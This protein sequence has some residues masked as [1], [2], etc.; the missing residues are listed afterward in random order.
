MLWSREI[1]ELGFGNFVKQRRPQFSI[2]VSEALGVYRELRAPAAD[3]PR[4]VARV[5]GLL[6][7]PRIFFVSFSFTTPTSL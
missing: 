7:T 2:Y 3:F 1:T 5:Y 6:S 4:K